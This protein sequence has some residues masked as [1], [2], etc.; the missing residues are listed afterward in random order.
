MVHVNNDI[1]KQ[2]RDIWDLK[3][4][5]LR[6]SYLKS[7]EKLEKH[8]KLQQPLFIGDKVLIQNQAG[9]FATKWEK[10]GRVVETHANDQ[11]TVK[12]DGSGRLTLRNRQFLKKAVEHDLYGQVHQRV[13]ADPQQSAV[14]D[15]K[16]TPNVPN[17]GAPPPPSTTWPGP[18]IEHN[19]TERPAYD[20]EGTQ[21]PLDIQGPNNA[22]N[23]END[24]PPVT[25][26]SPSTPLK[27]TSR[28]RTSGPSSPTPTPEQKPISNALERELKR[29]EDFN[30]PG[31][32]EGSHPPSR[33]RSGK[34]FLS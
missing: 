16:L 30:H 6:T 7:V 13:A 5:A 19:D 12:V 33:T 2:W 27:P 24:Y 34:R 18:D 9:R 17:T 32:K 21:L 28:T 3:E 1:D 25:D 8:T 4:K 10:T 29:T 26:V 31:K 23:N 11:Y 14:P 15:P 22:V 20:K